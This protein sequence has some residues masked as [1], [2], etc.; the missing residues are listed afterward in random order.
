MVLTSENKLLNKFPDAGDIGK[1][2]S[3]S[4]TGFKRWQQGPVLSNFLGLP[5]AKITNG[6]RCAKADCLASGSAILGRPDF[7]IGVSRRQS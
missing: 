3:I 7:A 5:E 1:R 2:P 6:A 4:G